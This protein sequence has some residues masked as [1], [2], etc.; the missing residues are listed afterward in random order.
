MSDWLKALLSVSKTIVISVAIII[1]LII[2][3]TGVVFGL[4]I[5]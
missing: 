3:V 2:L 1:G 5:D 4:I